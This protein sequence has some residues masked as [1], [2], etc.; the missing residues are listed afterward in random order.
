MVPWAWLAPIPCLSPGIRLLTLVN[1]CMSHPPFKPQAPGNNF[2]MFDLLCGAG[3]CEHHRTQ[4]WGKEEG[5]PG[6]RSTM[7]WGDPR[8]LTPPAAELLQGL[9]WAKPS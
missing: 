6:C 9:L 3:G 7:G 2:K 4:Q 5:L 8:P 1:P